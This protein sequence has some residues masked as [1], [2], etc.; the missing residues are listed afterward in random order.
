MIARIK[1]NDTVVVLSGKDKGKQGTVIEVLPEKDKVMV[2]GVCV[3]TKHAKAKKAGDVAGIRKQEQ[4]INCSK[5]MP[6]CG[7][8]KKA[9]RVSVKVLDSGKKVRIC[10]HC[11]ESF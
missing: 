8:C 1:K 4:Y 2:K 10:C 9:C 6:V 7:A 3:I 11:S 5:V